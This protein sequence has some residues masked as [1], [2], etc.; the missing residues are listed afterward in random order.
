MA[1]FTGL[2]QTLSVAKSMQQLGFLAAPVI[3]AANYG[4]SD[5]Q[6]YSLVSVGYEYLYADQILMGFSDGR[7]SCA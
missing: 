3:T 1:W 6:M 7:R 2:L 4:P 5:R